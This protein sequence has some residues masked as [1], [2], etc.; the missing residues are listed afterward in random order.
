[1]MKQIKRYSWIIPLM[2][3]SIIFCAIDFNGFYGQDSHEYLRFAGAL[4]ENGLTKEVLEHF[5]WPV[6]YPFIA[7]VVSYLGLPLSWAMIA[8]SFVSLVGIFIVLDKMIRLMYA[9]DSW[10]LLLIVSTQVY[11]VR[12]GFIGMSDILCTFFILLATYHLLLQRNEFKWYRIFTIL[13]FGMCAVFTRYAA[14][15]LI[16][17]IVMAVGLSIFHWMNRS[18][19]IWVSLIIV[20]SLVALSFFNNRL[21][22]LSSDLW[23]EWSFNNVINL[24][25]EGNSGDLSKWVPNI[26][27][28]FGGFF[29]IGF[30]SIGVLLIPFYK[31]VSKNRFLWISVALY[32]LLIV[33]L[34]T[35]NYRF[36]ILTY[37][38]VLLLVF[39]AF[40]QLL[41]WLRRKRL[42]LIF[43][44]GTLL[45][46]S[47]FFYYSFS[48]TYSVNAAERVISQA[49][50]SEKNPQPIYAFYVD[51]SFTTYGIENEVRNLYLQRYNSFEKG[52]LVVYNEQKLTPQWKNTMVGENWERLKK[53]CELDTIITFE[54]GWVIYEIK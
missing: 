54:T 17:P 20:F 43:V 16:V 52:A 34:N 53:S 5:H 6:L 45:F 18:Q 29:H 9:G 46:N 24:K 13:L 7:V 10:L 40:E 22:L 36:L 21:Y 30:L 11:F 1:M 44:A 23:K 49:I 37:P 41:N 39:P 2:V 33:G 51:Q 35:Q 38:F 3:I 27:Y 19:R 12:A 4:K 14:I 15:I 28:V 48:K 47:A 42:E 8:I 31:H 25:G 50:L 32:A 26:V